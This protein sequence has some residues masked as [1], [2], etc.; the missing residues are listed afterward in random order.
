MMPYILHAG[1]ILSCCLIFYKILLQKETFYKLNRFVLF[2]CLLLSF[3]LPLLPV[4]QQFSLRKSE[5][6]VLTNFAGPV[7]NPTSANIQQLS[8]DQAIH[9]KVASNKDTLNLQQ[10]ITWLMWLYWFGVAAFGLTFLIQLAT[11]LS[12]VYAH[13]VI[14]DGR[15]TIVEFPGDKAPCTFGNI[16]FIN[17]EKYD[18]DTYN[19]ILLHEK[20]HIENKHSLDILLAEIVL[21]FQWFNPFAWAYRK[22]LENNLEFLTDDLMLTEGK[23]DR[24][25]YQMNLLKVSAP[26]FPLS[27]TTNYNQSLLKKRVIMMTAKKSNVNTTWKYLFLLPVLVIS[28]CLLNEP[29]ASAQVADKKKTQQKQ[30]NSQ[31]KTEGIWF[32]TIKKD[33]LSIQFKNEGEDRDSYNGSTF[34]ITEF[35]DF[36]KEKQG[37]FSLTREAGT[38][39]FTGRFDGDKGMGNYKFVPDRGFYDYLVK[40]GIDME[41]DEDVMV[42]F[43]VNVNKSTVQMLKDNGYPKFKKNDL[44]P[45]AALKV[46]EAYIKSLKASGIT[47]ISLGD[48][49]PLKSLGVT[50]DYIREIKDAGYKNV[51]ASQL[52]TFRAT[53][54]DGK[55]IGDIRSSSK[56]DIKPQADKKPAAGADSKPASAHVSGNDDDNDSNDDLDDIVAMKALNV[57]AAYINS[58]K[59][60]GYDHLRNS[61]LIAMKAQGIDG[62]YI[63][64]LQQM[65]YKD[66][67]ASDLI[68]I[69]SQNITQEYIK[70]FENIGYSSVPVQDLIPLKSLGVTATY[71][72][73]FHDI[74]YKDLSLHDA[75]P[76]K[77]Q[78]ITPALI[79]QYKE[80]GFANISIEDVISAKATGTTP[81]FIKTMKEKGHNMKSIQKYIQLKVVVE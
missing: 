66:I 45:L 39:H 49:V 77:A 19:Q 21:I 31:M 13:P 56:K 23:V 9:L 78:G 26:H 25:S 55:F 51:S 12:R 15:F 54:I 42:F 3:S 53:G 5:A 8:P 68:A 14:K 41:D 18:W 74:G 62:D 33:E 48:L 20:I 61:D 22:E 65:G 69:K 79:Q 59:N 80:A 67:K 16:I 76:L 34:P 37:A 57:D 4:P 50:G 29:I 75:I 46:D 35:K 64:H 11:I 40:E 73:G 1:I 52:I 17:P 30:H 36:Q 2:V 24:T 58:L 81:S 6:L 43:M 47:K 7:L 71:V 27:L 72:K 32:A 44:I 10:I 60:A 63:K 70:S 28:V 38:M